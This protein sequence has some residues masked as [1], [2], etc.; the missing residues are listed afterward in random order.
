MIDG[1][2][3]KDAR[4]S[5]SGCAMTAKSKMEEY[6]LGTS[7]EELSRLGFQ[8]QVWLEETSALWRRAGFGAGK[9]LIDL[10]CGPGFAT[11]DFS[12]LVGQQGR[13][14]AIDGS[15]TYYHYLVRQI[16]LRKI[17]NVTPILTDVH[18][19]TPED[20]TADGIFAR[21]LLGFV[22]DPALVIREATRMLK[23]GGTFAIIDYINYL[24]ASIEPRSAALCKVFRAF[25][26]SVKPHGT[27]WDIGRILPTLLEEAGL[28]VMDISALCRVGRPGSP[29]WEWPR[30]F[31]KVFRP[32]LIEEN[33][34][35]EQEYD[36]I[37]REWEAL[38]LKPGA[39]VFTPPMLAIVAMK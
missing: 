34:L 20:G 36:Q 5:Q 7:L 25:Y 12:N 32:K 35:S 3:D 39:F 22:K 1:S 16:E 24:A 23:P 4:R 37:D 31:F 28:K 38:A 13:V 11:F 27:N 2:S 10:G 14:I 8:H 21:W 9:T 19:P 17:S 33:I 6:V 29:Y 26:E 30:R 15:E 18:S